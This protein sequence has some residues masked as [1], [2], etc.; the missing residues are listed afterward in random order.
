MKRHLALAAVVLLCSCAPTPH[1]VRAVHV[2][3]T[4]GV[5]GDWAR[6]VGG[7]RVLVTS[8]LTGNEDT[9]TYEA[10]PEDARKLADADV[11]FRV[12]LGLEEWLDPVVRNAANGRLRIVDASAGVTGLVQGDAEDRYGNP[13]I[14]LDPQY[15]KVGV[16]NLAAA[17]AAVDPKGESLYRARQAAYGIRLDSL[18]SA[19]A[20]RMAALSDRRFIALHDA[21]PY[22]ARRFGLDK[23]ENIEAVPGKEPSAREIARIIDRINREH[24]RLI[25]SEPQLSSAIPDMLARETGIR[26]LVINP[27]CGGTDTS[28]DYIAT[29]SSVAGSIATALDSGSQMTR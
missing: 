7:D 6:Q 17:L 25:L 21:W 26:V 28:L 9:H 24:I 18:T 10:K 12:G 8:L 16:A 1:K 19:I 11:L 27:L 15:A 29:M 4:I 5:L 22:F 23:V 13:H 2:V 20:A 3:T 14:W